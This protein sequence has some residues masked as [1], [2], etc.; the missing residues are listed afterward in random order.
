MVWVAEP[1]AAR[2]EAVCTPSR[3]EPP[4]L[5]DGLCEG[6]SWRGD[7]VA[8][9]AEGEDMVDGYVEVEVSCLSERHPVALHP[10]RRYLCSVALEHAGE[11]RLL[12]DFVEEVREGRILC[13]DSRGICVEETGLFQERRE[14]RLKR[15]GRVELRSAVG[16]DL[17]SGECQGRRRR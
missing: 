11:G 1:V 9:G 17:N 2:R 4:V 5:D 12:V 14:A 3:L 16:V 10:R 7:A 15:S 8:V 13:S 6:F